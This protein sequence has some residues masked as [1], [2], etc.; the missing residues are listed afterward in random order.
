MALSD[1]S[2]PCLELEYRQAE[3]GRVKFKGLGALVKI[4]NRVKALILIPVISNL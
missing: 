1:P 3:F 4:F 2:Y